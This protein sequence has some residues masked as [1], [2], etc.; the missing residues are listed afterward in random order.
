[1]T[2]STDQIAP[3]NPYQAPFV[4]VEKAPSRLRMSIGFMIKALVIGALVVTAIYFGYAAHRLTI[5]YPGLND[6]SPDVDGYWPAVANFVYMIFAAISGM[7]AI[8]IGA[9][10]GYYSFTRRAKM[11]TTQDT[12]ATKPA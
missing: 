12:E 10:W 2:L 7:L 6:P 5:D 1:M 9:I 11:L 3:P 8:I 4:S